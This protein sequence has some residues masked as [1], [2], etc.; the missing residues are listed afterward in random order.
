M[1][2]VLLIGSGAREHSIAERIA[3]SAELY[4]FMGSRNPG[5]LNLAAKAE[6][7]NLKK[8][9]D[10]LKFALHVN[11]DYVFVGPEEPLANGVADLLIK[12]GISVCGPTRGGARLE[13]DKG[14]CRNLLLR[15]I[16]K[17][18]PKFAVCN[19]IKEVNEAVR[20]IDAELVVKPAGLTGGKGVKVQGEHLRDLAEA[21]D[22]AYEIV[23]AQIGGMS[24]VVIEEKLEGEEFSLQVFTDGRRVEPMP[25]VQD[26]KRA[27]ENDTGP[28]TGGMGSYSDANGLLPFV[29]KKDLEDAVKIMEDSIAALRKDSG[30]EFRGVLY[31]G[32]MLTKKGPMLLEYNV[33]FGDPEAMNVLPILKTDFNSICISILEGR[34]GHVD[35]EKAATV[36]KYLVPKGYPDS[37]VAEVPVPIDPAA[38]ENAGAKLYYASVN[39]KDGKLYATKSRSFGIVGLGETISEAEKTCQSAI[40]TVD[41]AN[42]F[43]RKDIGTEKLV[44]KRVEHMKIIAKQRNI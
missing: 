26:H 6:V 32:F 22:Y 9:E 23:N 14:F 31:G 3:Q 34:L 13:S 2:K 5:I 20:E 42:L 36:C 7:G 33:R 8:S 39:L 19:T 10:I 30:I 28:N 40:S 29:G 17:G 35:F 21:R 15:H 18:L 12:N 1:A 16:K 44:Q 24:T 43:Y 25:L 4:A 27:F 37:P 11:P 41:T 38:V